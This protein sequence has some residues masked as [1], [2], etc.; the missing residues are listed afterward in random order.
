M[1]Q[2]SLLAV[3]GGH[4][5]RRHE[6]AVRHEAAREEK[7]GPAAMMMVPQTTMMKVQSVVTR[8]DGYSFRRHENAVTTQ[9]PTHEAC[10]VL[11]FPFVCFATRLLVVKQTKGNKRTKQASC[12]G[13]CVVTAFS[14]RHPR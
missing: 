8:D 11:L 5:D 2:Q 4:R 1:P 14:C 3:D 12:V 9:E 6:G 13:S 7:A 10:L